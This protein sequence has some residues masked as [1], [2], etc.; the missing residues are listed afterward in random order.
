MTDGFKE[1]FCFGTY[2]GFVTK[3]NM[4][5]KNCPL[6]ILLQFWLNGF[7]RL[8]SLFSL[9]VICQKCVVHFQAYTNSKFPED[10]SFN[11]DSIYFPI[12][13]Y[14]YSRHL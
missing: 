9:R 11:L 1:M 10:N 5:N 2:V 4:T 13:F 3:I 12:M 14:A 6:I 8:R 7:Q